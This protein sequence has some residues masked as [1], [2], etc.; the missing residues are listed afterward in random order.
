LF[1]GDPFRCRDCGWRGWRTLDTGP[2]HVERKRSKAPRFDPTAALGAVVLIVLLGAAVGL[3]LVLNSSM[4]SSAPR[5]TGSGS[6]AG[7]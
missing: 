6:G 4:F 7:Q 5:Y 3:M 1:G 2:A